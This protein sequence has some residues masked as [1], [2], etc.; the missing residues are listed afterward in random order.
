MV[1]FSNIPYADALQKSR[2]QDAML[3]RFG[4]FFLCCIFVGLWAA[5][6]M[7]SFNVT[8]SIFMGI[9]ILF[10]WVGKRRK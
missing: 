5:L 6:D 8:M 3:S 4:I 2:K 7:S 1:S 10:F 9:V